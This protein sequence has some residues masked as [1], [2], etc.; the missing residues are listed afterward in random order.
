[1][2]E[3]EPQSLLFIL[4][5]DRFPENLGNLSEQQ[6]ERLHQNITVMEERYQGRWDTHMIADYCWNL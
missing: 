2:S 1:M 5:L 6:G 4:P 3:N